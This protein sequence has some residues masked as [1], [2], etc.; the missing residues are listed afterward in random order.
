M[1]TLN[2]AFTPVYKVKKSKVCDLLS[3]VKLAK[4][5]IWERFFFASTDKLPKQQL[6]KCF[7]DL[8]ATSVVLYS[9][10]LIWDIPRHNVTSTFQYYSISL[11][12]LNQLL[13]ALNITFNLSETNGL[14][15]SIN[16]SNFITLLTTFFETSEIKSILSRP[17]EASGTSKFG[18]VSSLDWPHLRKTIQFYKLTSAQNMQPAVNYVPFKLSITLNMQQIAK[19]KHLNSCNRFYQPISTL[20][21]HSIKT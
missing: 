12:N 11:A 16:S 18:N 20:P 8:R 7:I 17:C 2:Q 14:I 10:L 4:N 1:A 19:F 6:F 13:T 3:S 9:I 15:S 21:L 5:T